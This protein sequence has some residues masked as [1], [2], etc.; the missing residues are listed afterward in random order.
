MNKRPYNFAPG[1]AQLP[2]PVLEKVRAETMSYRGTGVS[3]MEMSHRSP[4]FEDIIDRAEKRLRELLGVPDSW[5]VLFLQGGASL[6]FSMVPMNLYTARRTADYVCSGHWAQRA[7]EEAARLGTVRVVAS[8]QAEGFVR[9]PVVDPASLDPQADYLHITWN[10]T[11]YGTRSVS[12]PTAGSVPVVA[13]MSSSLLSER[14]EVS[15]FGLIYAAAQ[16]NIGPAGLTI[17]I[18]RRDLLERAGKDLPTMLCYRTHAKGRS[19]YNTPPCHA[20]YVAGLVLDWIAETGGLG[21]MEDRNRRK[22]ETLY[23]FLDSSRTFRARVNG[24]DRS[25]MNVTFGLPTPELETRFVGQAERAGLL[26]LAGHRTAG[27]MRASLYNAMSHEGV[28]ALVAFMARFEKE[29]G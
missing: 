12:C 19:L 5:A 3:V 9:V 27:G 10:N 26:S 8:S 11:I 17:V 20:V 23:T 18:V 2:E 13:D 15:R 29:N 14:I 16:K 6:Q 21:A 25:F 22:A 28:D 24:P 7:I 1:P 4:E